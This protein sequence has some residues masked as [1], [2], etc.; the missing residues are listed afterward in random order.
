MMKL[1]LNLLTYKETGD[2]REY[3]RIVEE[4]AAKAL[5]DQRAS[6]DSL[7]QAGL[8]RLSTAR[9]Q[10]LDDRLAESVKIA[11]ISEELKHCLR[12]TTYTFLNLENPLHSCRTCESYSLDTNVDQQA[13]ER[14]ALDAFARLSA[15]ANVEI[16]PM[17]VSASATC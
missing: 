6:A 10:R 8:P 11:L 16:V 1:K 9:E 17:A 4:F 15:C 7:S 14:I 12:Q 13:F 5:P 3:A 2:E